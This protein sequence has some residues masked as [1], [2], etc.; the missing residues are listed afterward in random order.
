MVGL[1]QMNWKERRYK[2]GDAWEEK[3]SEDQE[4]RVMR[5]F[6]IRMQEG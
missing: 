6:C 5:N 3:K 2:Q 1:E 4:E